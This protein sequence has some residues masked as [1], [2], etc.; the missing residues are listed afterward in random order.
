MHISL[1]DLPLLGERMRQNG[2][3]SAMKEIQH[4]IIH[5]SLPCPKL[6]DAIASVIG[7]GAAEFVSCLGKPRDA[8]DAF[9]ICPAIA[10]AKLRKPFHHWRAATLLLVKEDRSRWHAPYLYL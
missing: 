2:H 1:R 5:A 3:V 4:T 8:G 9:G 6:V 7:L 10:P